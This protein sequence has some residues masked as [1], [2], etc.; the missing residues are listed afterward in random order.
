M[1][2][3]LVFNVQR[4]SIHDGPGIRTTVFVK[5]CP[6]RCLWCHNPEAMSGR[7]EFGYFPERCI[8]CYDCTRACP[9]GVHAV[10]DGR[11][12]VRRDRCQ[13]DGHCTDV[14]YAEALERLGR[15][16][17]VEEAVAQAERDRPFYEASGGGVTIS[18]GEPLRQAEFTLAFLGLCRERGLHTTLDTCG[19]ASWSALEAVAT[20]ADLILFDVKHLDSAT[21]R[22]LTGVPNEL[23]LENLRRLATLEGRGRITVRVPFIPGCN[24]QLAN[25][26]ALGQL[27]ESLQRSA[28]GEVFPVDLLPYHELGLSKY[29]KLDR[30]YPLDGTRP[31]Q[32]AQL[33]EAG[34]ILREYGLSPRIG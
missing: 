30:P 19:Y 23:I 24:D 17:T 15:W 13:G 5:G 7:I 12:V 16:M 1:V 18:G 28:G 31:P 2:Q 8:A 29:R 34:A 4:Y 33:R 22:A 6:L 26:H 3:G 27:V 10:E 14:C 9:N 11:R 25:V 21:H 32:P 20:R